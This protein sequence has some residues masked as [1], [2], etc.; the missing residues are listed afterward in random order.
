[1]IDFDPDFAGG[2]DYIRLYRS[3]GWQVVPANHP[4][5]GSNWKRPSIAWKANQSTL[6]DEDTLEGWFRGRSTDQ[7]G[8][9]TGAASGGLFVIDL[10]THKT[11]AAS[12]W[13]QALLTDHDVMMLDT[14]MQVTGG[15]G[16]QIFLRAPASWMPPTNKTSIGVDIRGQGGFVMAPPSSHESGKRYD[17]KP[18]CG[19]W[20]KPVMEAPRWL[21]DAIDK[22]VREHG[23]GS[24]TGPAER[25]PG[26]NNPDGGILRN[27]LT[28]EVVDGRETYMTRIVWAALV[29]AYRE[30][31]IMSDALAKTFMMKA[32]E[33]YVRNVKSR[34]YEPSTPKHFLLEREGRGI[35]MFREK[36]DHA[37]AKWDHEVRE[38]AEKAP[39]Q[40][41]EPPKDRVKA[42]D[43]GSSTT[44]DGEPDEPTGKEQNTG[45]EEDFEPQ[46]GLTPTPLFSYDQSKIPPRQWVYGRETILKFVSLLG[47][48]GGVGK[49]AKSMVDAFS[50]ALGY[51]LIERTIKSFYEAVHTSGA[52]WI[53]NGED[54]ID[55]ML[56]RVA[57]IMRHYRLTPADFKHPIY[58]DS[59]RNQP[60]IITQRTDGGLIASPIVDELV[61]ALIAKNIK[62]LVVDPFAHTHTAEE[63]RNEEMVKVMALWSQVADQ[64]NCAIQLVHHFRK[65]GTSG[66]GE[67]FRGASAL[68]GAARV[69]TTLSAMS[70]EDAAKLGIKSEDRRTYIR[71]DNAKANMAPP[72]DHA[73][74]FQLVSVCLDNATDD[75]PADYVQVV[76]AWDPPGLFDGVSDPL[77]AKMLEQIEAG[78]PGEK[79]KIRYILR[80]RADSKV[81]AGDVIID[82]IMPPDGDRKNYRSRAQSMLDLW[83]K[84]GFIFEKMYPGKDRSE[85]LHVFVDTQKL[86]DFKRQSAYAPQSEEE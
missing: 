3:L 63:N 78:M 70:E 26:P 52:V 48:P 16:W 50:V 75:Y 81:W 58:L 77:T 59:G 41:P 32:F 73:H 27:T 35:T 7:L 74:W 51:S 39:P 21:C 55:E 34:M 86:A 42:G 17:W 60:I 79:E 57:G 45:F 64:A 62:L 4:S 71:S 30:S 36:W 68:Q 37:Y 8:I 54:P 46:R 9:I 69:M 11:H 83:K 80:G 65:G 20:E 47:S 56:R 14:P 6:A 49:T 38:A 23:G 61:A 67:S 33:T 25:Q 5:N 43:S 72:A 24:T 31:P 40:K 12:D 82:H 10:D 1:M 15:G 76:D 22:L 29:N 84:D 2:G 53:F 18:G 13:W 19:P 28:D 66:D 85:R 44:D